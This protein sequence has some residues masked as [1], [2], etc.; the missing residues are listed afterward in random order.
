ME[1]RVALTLE[2][3]AYLKRHTDTF[4]G[5]VRFAHQQDNWTCV[6]DDFVE[7]TLATTGRGAK[8][9]RGVIGRITE[10]LASTARRR[11]IPTVNVWRNSP[12]PNLYGVYPD[13]WIAAE[14]AA[15]HF[16]D[17]GVRRLACVFR[18]N[19]PSEQ[20]LADRFKKYANDAGCPCEL[21]CVNIR[22]AHS[23]SAWTK[24]QALIK[25][26]L[27]TATF[28]VGVLTSVDMLGRHVAQLV[29]ESR[30]MVPRDVAIVSTHNEPT[31]CQC[32]EPTL[33]SI[34]FGFDRIGYEAARLLGQLLDGD[35]PAQKEVFVPPRELVIRQS[36]DFIFSHDPTVTLAMQF[37]SQNA[38][39]PINVDRVAHHVDVSRRTLEKKFELHAGHTVAAELRR[40][41]IDHAKRLLAGSDSP[42]ADVAKATGF[43]TSNQLA[44]VF[45]REVKMTPREYRTQR[46]AQNNWSSS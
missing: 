27:E 11:R 30:R 19:D 44:R 13:L 2:L 9:Y 41:R 5:A 1:T 16:L 37:I 43:A 39:K 42:I 14:M 6:I 23:L 10:K 31:I 29:S 18:G 34:E 45:R 21:I 28:P 24:T 8:P 17:R 20:H 12:V 36:S 33:S 40:V 35:N 3:T 15:Q 25:G 26:W 22:F 46:Q 38:H 7:H 32:P 4:A